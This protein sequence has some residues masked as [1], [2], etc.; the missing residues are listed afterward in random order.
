M[1]ENQKA[2]VLVYQLIMLL[3]SMINE[4]E[5]ET[6]TI[7][8]IVFTKQAVLDMLSGWLRS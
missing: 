6:Y 7:N 4:S 1:N 8:G 5:K 2:H 3:K